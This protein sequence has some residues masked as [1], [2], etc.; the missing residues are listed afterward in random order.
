MK[1]IVVI[2]NLELYQDQKERLKL[3][4][5]VTFYDDLA[6]TPEEWLGRCKGADIVCSGKAG[7]K[8]K[9]YELKNTFF[10]LPFV[11][12]GWIDKDKIRENNIMVSYCPGCNRDA[13]S[14]WAVAMILVLFRQLPKFLKADD[15]PKNKIPPATSGLTGKKIAIL[16]KGN[17]GSRVGK[18]C[19]AFGM[20]INYFKRDD[21]LLE[22]AKDADAVINCLASDQ[23]TK[24]LLDR[25]FFYSLKKG[26][27]FI[28]VTDEKIYDI[29]ALI[30]SLD[31]GILAGAADDAGGI[32]VGDVEDPVYKKL[33]GHPKILV[34]PHIAY[35]T[36]TTNR[37]ANDRMIE[38]IEAWL[39]GKPINLLK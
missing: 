5:N 31:N 25:K 1:K 13:V 2:P 16:G 27:Y 9:I 33:A 18:I 34:T 32:K 17:V 39:E 14:E 15:L 12:V 11:G 35:Q 26:A 8:E 20:K 4:G 37:V 38:N 29:D 7:L 21:N 10:S 23:A 19:E 22:C 36:D 30:G 3:L 28:S 24:G 6:Q